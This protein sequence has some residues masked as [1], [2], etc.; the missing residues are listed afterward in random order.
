MKPTTE[1]EQLAE[2]RRQMDKYRREYK[3]L[4]K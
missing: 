3:P 4:T 2:L 1:A